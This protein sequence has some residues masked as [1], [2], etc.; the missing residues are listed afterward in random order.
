MRTSNGQEN[1]K[2]GSNL[3][4]LVPTC[5]SSMTLTRRLTLAILYGVGT[6]LT[7]ND[8]TRLSM[9]HTTPPRVSTAKCGNLSITV[10]SSNESPNL[11]IPSLQRRMTKL[12]THTYAQDCIAPYCS[13]AMPLM[14]RTSYRSLSPNSIK[15]TISAF[16]LA[17]TILPLLLTPSMSNQATFQTQAALWNPQKPHDVDDKANTSWWFEICAC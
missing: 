12:N 2:T 5:T 14:S 9:P 10:S 7:P 8:C 11:K 4:P 16:A 13:Y 3:N 6:S 1:I 15:P 17:V